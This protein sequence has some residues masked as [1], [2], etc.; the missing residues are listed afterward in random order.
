MG[1]SAPVAAPAAGA[2]AGAAPPGG[3]GGICPAGGY[4][5][6]YGYWGPSGFSGINLAGKDKTNLNQSNKYY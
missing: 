1:F 4:I 6:G 2:G 3:G 5:P